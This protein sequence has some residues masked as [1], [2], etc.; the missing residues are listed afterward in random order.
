MGK[1]SHARELLMWP[2]RAQPSSLRWRLLAAMVGSVVVISSVA[3]F[4]DYH[5][6]RRR[7]VGRVLLSLEEQAGALEAADVLMAEPNRFGQYVDEYCATMDE[8][9]SP[10]HHILIL[11]PNGSVLASSRHHSGPEVE[12]ALLRA[13]GGHAV[14]DVD[15]HRLAYVRSRDPKGRTFVLAQYLDRVEAVLHDQLR[16]RALLIVATALIIVLFVYL[17]VAYWVLGPLEKLISAAQ[18]WSGRD[19]STRVPLCGPSDL[20]IV[21]QEFNSMAGQLEVQEQRRLNELEEA[22]HIQANLLPRLSPGIGGLTLAAEYRPAAYVAGDLYDVFVL[23]DG[24]TVAAVLD[25][26]G[27]GISAALLTGVVKIAL[28][29]H[30]AGGADLSEA[31]RR[32]NSDIV[33]CTSDSHFVTACVG[34]WSARENRWTYCA[35]GHPGGILIHEGRTTELPST[36]PLL[37]VLPDGAWGLES[38]PIAPQDRIA[39]YTDGIIEAQV[40]GRQFGVEGLR[41]ALEQTCSLNPAEQAQAVLQRVGSPQVHPTADDATVVIFQFPSV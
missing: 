12:R 29:H 26:S 15:G 20:Q 10:G 9:I 13:T 36:A 39:L 17:A 23:P 27:H 38:V 28:R 22:R 11:D 2:W 5:R 34:I 18:R 1:E 7:D 4:W 16:R 6:E 24:R 19:F 25:V 14:I 8:R 35:A 33:A 40:N 41:K 32:V 31:I 3:A 30:V 37:G 21:A